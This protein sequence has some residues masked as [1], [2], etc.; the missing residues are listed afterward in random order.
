MDFYFTG[1]VER[2]I[3]ENPSSFFK[4]LLL[5]IEDTDSDFNDFEIIVTGTIADVIEG[6][7]YTFWGE[8]TQHPKY[9]EQLKVSR[10]EK[11]KPTSSGLIKYF[12]SDHFKGIGLKTAERIVALYGED[13]IDKILENP[14]QLETISGFSKLAREN[15]LTKLKLNYGTEQIIA[16]LANYGLSSHLAFQVFETYK[17]EALDILQSNPYQLVE[18]IKGIGFKIADQ[19]AQQIGID[20]NAPQ[21]LRAALLHCLLEICLERGDTYVESQELL[22]KALLLLENTRP[23]E[24]APQQLAEELAELLRDGKMQSIS[25]KIFENSLFYAEA[26]IHNYLQKL[27]NT[28]LGEPFKQEEIQEAIAQAQTKLNIAYD[29]IQKNAIAQAI[30]SKV[31]ILTGGP[32]TGKT[33][34]IKGLIETYAKLHSIDLKQKELP[35]LLAAPTGR[36]AR[37]MSDLTGLSSATIHR[38]LGLNGDNDY[39][40]LDDYLDADLIIVDEFSMVDTWLA[41]QLLA[42]ISSH[43]QV[44]IVGDSD[45]LPSVGPG[46]VLSDLLEINSIPQLA[47]TKI[48]RQSEES[49]II[50]LANAINAGR[51]PQ[52]FTSKKAD[53]SYFEVQSQYIPDTIVKIIDAALRNGIAKEDIQILAPMYRGQAGITHLNTILQE[54][55][56]PKSDEVE[57]VYNDMIFRMGDKI[58]HLVNEPSQNV[59]NGDIGYIVELIPAKYSDSKQDE[60]LLNFD[61]NEVIYPRKDWQKITLAYAMSIHKSQ[62]SEFPVVILPITSQSQ[63]MLQRNLI[64]TA[65]T[66]AKSKLILLGQSQAFLYAAQHQGTSRKTYLVQRFL[67]ELDSEEKSNLNSYKNLLD[68]ASKANTL[69]EESP[70]LEE[71][72]HLTLDKIGHIDPMIGLRQEDFDLFFRQKAK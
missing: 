48:F 52:D 12:A 44:I 59:F 21:R 57:F 40:T 64:Y 11:S 51:L 58:L 53:R 28:P 35:I 29:D 23:V 19:L 67:G 42:A 30:N 38:H 55:F 50:P 33:T 17:E 69:V 63:R 27:L 49:T 32:G 3:F 41:H 20:S 72:Y 56:N 18:D 4:I 24:I 31:F 22:E 54:K 25:T 7:H 6:D 2:L 5:S 15:F 9:G 8:L 71:D 68:D 14:K 43:T 16:K 1:T 46:Q 65:I 37:R 45:Q 34:V 61:G 13:A 36:A 39:Q 26:G 60:L 66:R 10:Y 47:L 62:G 70:Q